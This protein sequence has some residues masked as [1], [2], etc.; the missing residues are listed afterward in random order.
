M[1]LVAA[2]ADI[3]LTRAGFSTTIFHDCHAFLDRLRSL[4][5]KSGRCSLLGLS[6]WPWAE[7]VTEA[8]RFTWLFWSLFSR[9]PTGKI[10]CL[11]WVDSSCL[12]PHS[13][14]QGQHVCVYQEQME[15]PNRQ[16]DLKGRWLRSWDG[17][18]HQSWALGLPHCPASFITPE[19]FPEAHFSYRFAEACLSTGSMTYN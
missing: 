18:T 11:L 14:P 16:A 7:C 8:A 15:I 3:V 10:M 19:T 2:V 4:G 9:E 17:L 5:A 1:P 6:G 13:L 12:W